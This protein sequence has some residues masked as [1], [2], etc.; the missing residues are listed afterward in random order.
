MTWPMP[1]EEEVRGVKASFLAGVADLAPR[2]VD[3]AAEAFET[4]SRPNWALEWG[5]SRWVGEGLGLPRDTIQSLVLANVYM[6]A[7]GRVIDDLADGELA[8]PTGEFAPSALMTMSLH[9]LWLS[10]YA[11]LFAGRAEETRRFWSCF[12]KYMAQWIEML[13]PGVSAP[14]VFR[15]YC[16]SDWGRLAWQG[17]PVKVSCAAA[18]LLADRGDAISLVEEAADDLMIAVVMLDATFDWFEDLDGCRYN[19]FAA[20]CS[21]LP[22]TPE[23]VQANRRAVLEELHLHGAAQPYFQI[24]SERLARA[25]DAARRLGCPAVSEFA[26]SLADESRSCGSWAVEQATERINTALA[27]AGKRVQDAPK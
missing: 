13:T 22:Q 6:V 11:N 4:I 8:V 1:S 25:V 10:Q 2:L 3:L 16:D 24:I 14:P 19:V 17:A 26:H 21:N 23:N 18:C 20:Y 9:H 7:F 15:S 12:R 5:L 27:A